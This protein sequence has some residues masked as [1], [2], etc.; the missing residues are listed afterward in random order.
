M[1]N[2]K[3]LLITFLITSSCEMFGP[4]GNTSIDYGRWKG[5]TCD[6]G[7]WRNEGFCDLSIYTLNGRYKVTGRKFRQGIIDGLGTYSKVSNNEVKISDGPLSGYKLKFSTKGSSGKQ[8][9]IFL[10]LGNEVINVLNP[11]Y[12]Y[13]FNNHSVN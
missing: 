10:Y 7:G 1:K 5:S 2:L 6:Y 11:D 3:Y 4:K 9:K 8:G 13:N 12:G